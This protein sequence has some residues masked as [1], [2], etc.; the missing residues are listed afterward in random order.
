M[1][2]VNNSIFTIFLASFH[3]AS[4]AVYTEE[5]GD[6]LSSKCPYTHDCSLVHCFICFCTKFFWTYM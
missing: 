2:L 4:I 1:R 6:D 3:N 5:Y